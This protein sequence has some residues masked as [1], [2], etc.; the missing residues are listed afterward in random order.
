MD[1]ALGQTASTQTSPY[2]P[3]LSPFHISN[4]LAAGWPTMSALPSMSMLM[5]T[6]TSP[7][8]TQAAILTN[9]LYS[10]HPAAIWVA[11]PMNC[12]AP[13]C[14]FISL[15]GDRDPYKPSLATLTGWGSVPPMY[16][17]LPSNSTIR[18]LFQDTVGEAA[19]QQWSQEQNR[20]EKREDFLINMSKMHSINVQKVIWKPTGDS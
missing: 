20:H 9:W 17:F 10:N 14:F 8:M 4:I 7:A 6:L 5:S 18:N 1:Q 13:G 3:H 11:I 2:S 12:D 16:P 19:A 15:V